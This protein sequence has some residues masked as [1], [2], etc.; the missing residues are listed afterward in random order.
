[1]LQEVV[2]AQGS[3]PSTNF[4]NPGKPVKGEEDQVEEI[5][6]FKRFLHK[7][8]LDLDPSDVIVGGILVVGISCAA[9]FF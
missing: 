6:S 7:F 1:M 2:E 4:L 3:G 8:G 9:F 5:S